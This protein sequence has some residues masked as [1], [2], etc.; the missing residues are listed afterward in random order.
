MRIPRVTF[1][2]LALL[3]AACTDLPISQQPGIT[4]A[5]GTPAASGNCSFNWATQ[6]LPDLT[7]KVQA[8]IKAAGLRDVSVVAEAYGENCYDSN[9]NQPVSFA[10]LE[11]DFHISIKVDDL[12]DKTSLGNLLDKVLVIMDAFPVGKTPGP[13]P[14]LINVSFQ[15]G[16][17]ELNL[18]FPVTLGKTAR[19]KG[20]QGAELL[21][22]LSSK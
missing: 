15:S 8:S 11:T 4:P 21:E 3:L 9:T 17:N 13:Q 1:L 18:S 12:K 14:G 5:T 10:A 2:L 19:E 16:S 22:T 20:L 7:E 6:P